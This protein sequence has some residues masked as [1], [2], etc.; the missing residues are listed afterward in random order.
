MPVNIPI[1]A[2]VGQFL[3]SLQQIQGTL[4]QMGAD[5]KAFENID[6][7]H[8]EIG[9]LTD[10]ARPPVEIDGIMTIRQCKAVALELD[11]TGAPILAAAIH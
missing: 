11:V 8:P 10:D 2:D 4:R 7:S 3:R 5:A 9:G 6:L 1:S